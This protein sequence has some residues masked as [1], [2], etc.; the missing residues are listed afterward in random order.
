[1]KQFIALVF[2]LI[3]FSG[4]SQ[5]TYPSGTIP[6][7]KGDSAWAQY[8]YIR[9]LSLGHVTVGDTAIRPK[10]NGAQRLWIN[11]SDTAIW[12]WISPKWNRSI[13]MSGGGG[14]GID[15]LGQGYGVIIVNDS[16]YDVDSSLIVNRDFFYNKIDSLVLALG[17]DSDHLVGVWPV[18]QTRSNDTIYTSLDSSFMVVTLTDGIKS[19]GFVSWSGT[20]LT[21]D[22]SPV[23]YVK[24]GVLYSLGA[25]QIT[26]SEA[27]PTDPRYDVP[28][29][30]E[31]PGFLVVE[32]DPEANPVIPQVDPATQLPL[33][34]ILVSAGDTIPTMTRYILYDI[35]AGSPTEANWATG[36]GLTASYSNLINPY[37]LTHSI[38][39]SPW[40]ATGI[41]TLTGTYGSSFDRTD[42]TLFKMRVDLVSDLPATANIQIK[43]LNNSTVVTPTITLTAAYGF[44]KTDVGYQNITV[45]LSAVAFNSNTFNRVVINV[46]GAGP[47]MWLDLIELQGGISPGGAP[48]TDGRGVSFYGK[49]SSGDSTILLLNDG[50]RFAAKDSVGTGGSGSVEY[51][52]S[53]Y[54][55]IVD[56]TD[57]AYTVNVDSLLI[58]NREWF[59]D[60]IDSLVATFVNLNGTGYV[61]MS[62]TTPSYQSNTQL[63]ADVNTFTQ[64][65]KGAVPAPTTLNGYFLKDDGTWAAGGS[66]VTTMSAFGSTPSAN[67]GIITGSNLALQPADATRPGGVSL[68]DQTLGAGT[69]SFGDGSSIGISLVTKSSINNGGAINM[70][71]LGSTRYATT[72]L[73]DYNNV[74]GASFGYGDSLVNETNLKNTFTIGPR[75]ANGRLTFVKLASSVPI[76]GM[77]ADGQFYMGDSLLNVTGMTGYTGTTVHLQGITAGFG[78]TLYYNNA[79]SPIAQIGYAGSSASNFSGKLYTYLTTGIDNVWYSNNATAK[80]FTIEQ[81]GSVSIGS[82]APAASAILDIQS[83]SKGLLLPRMTSVQ[84]SAISSP[85]DGLLIY[86][87]DTN[88][89]FTSVGGWLR[90]AGVWTAIHL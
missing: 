53:G 89:T 77:D 84:G 87:T 16:T 80:I 69:K 56:S 31:T 10:F 71:T 35:N 28:A 75:K 22:I 61:K 32:G 27:D 42:L 6:S 79:G 58:V 11:G 44:T 46:T 13:G 18:V 19:G 29:V 20:G 57:R 5:T 54:G 9:A 82:A 65:L 1:M 51:V 47:G 41:R 60:R 81:A 78:R 64:T 66:G 33:T 26:L 40:L 17:S 12:T 7:P 68:L 50:T 76:G 36:A 34:S 8:G 74:L 55:V 48:T 86:V 39:V 4:I 62:G 14:D 88:A 63:T 21:Y 83:T 52:L 3:C 2:I 24:N 15:E 49:N 70:Y 25:T 72:S 67:G 38:E 73:Y 30:D 85:A 45:P 43:F 23:I 90:I 37:S 59:Y